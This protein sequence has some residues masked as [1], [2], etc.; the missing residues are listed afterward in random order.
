MAELNYPVGTPVHDSTS[1]PSWVVAALFTPL[2]VPSLL[3]VAVY[4][5]HDTPGVQVQ[6]SGINVPAPPP[7][8]HFQPAPEKRC[9]DSARWRPGDPGAPEARLS[10][11]DSVPGLRT[12]QQVLT[13]DAKLLLSV[14]GLLEAEPS[15]LHLVSVGGKPVATRSLPGSICCADIS[16]DG[17]RV[18][19]GL[20]SGQIYV[21]EPNPGTAGFW[22]MG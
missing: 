8:H 19:A 20:H 18:V 15:R 1:L 7:L 17:K 9:A 13:A 16:A 11:V 21:W 2:I 4:C 22:A 14:E 12:F 3:F 5:L 6:A 10:E